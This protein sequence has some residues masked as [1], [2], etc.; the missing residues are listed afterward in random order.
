MAHEKNNLTPTLTPPLTSAIPDHELPIRPPN[1]EDLP[2]APPTD[3]E[4]GKSAHRNIQEFANLLLEFLSSASNES[5]AA[6]AVGL[7]ISTYLLLGRFGLVLIG[8]L[9]G[10]VL[11]AT[12][13][14]NGQDHGDNHAKAFELKRRREVGLDV[15]SRILDW[16]ETKTSDQ[17]FNGVATSFLGATS[18]E[19]TLLD[20]SSFRPATGAALDALTNAIIRD[21]VK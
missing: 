17:S 7:G 16:R 4:T 11:H 8:V 21:Y 13:E 9:G 19:H 20:Y 18:L 15:V 6:C 2:I 1:N 14:F 10:I 12:W 5:L 3:N